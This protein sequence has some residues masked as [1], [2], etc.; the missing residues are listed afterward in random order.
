MSIRF[1][2]PSPTR[3]GNGSQ[4]PS[5]HGLQW[6]TRLTP[7]SDM[8]VIHH[9]PCPPL[10]PS[11]RTTWPITAPRPSPGRRQTP[12]PG[13]RYG[14][15]PATYSPPMEAQ[16]SPPAPLPPRP[17]SPTGWPLARPR[18]SPC[19]PG[20]VPGPG[21]GPR[22]PRQSRPLWRPAKLTPAGLYT[23]RSR[24]VLLGLARALGPGAAL[25]IGSRHPGRRR[26]P[27]YRVWKWHPARLRRWATGRRPTLTSRAYQQLTTGFNSFLERP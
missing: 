12:P 1:I 8:G 6:P 25:E 11:A 27:P 19:G 21:P 10:P 7:R 24:I 23:L 17:L 15:T 3:P 16:G 5:R 4:N 22:H 26:G 14:A 18:W 20:Q 9:R 2:P 13:S